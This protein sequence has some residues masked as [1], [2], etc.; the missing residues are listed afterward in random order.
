MMRRLAPERYFHTRVRKG[1]SG[2]HDT[3][4]ILG[5]QQWEAGQ[6]LAKDTLS[7]RITGTNGQLPRRALQSTL[8]DRCEQVLQTPVTVRN[9]CR[10]TLPAYPPAEDRFHWRVLSHLGSGF[11]NMMS[12]AEVLRGTLALYNW[13]DDELCNRKLDAI[14]DVQHHR[15]QRFENGYLLR[16]LEVEI[17]LDSN[18]FT[19]DG[20]INLFGEMLNRFL[21]LYAD[22]NQFI[23]LS[24]I[25]RPEGKCIRWKE[26]HS[27]R[28]PG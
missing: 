12:R 9:L 6:E 14:L 16:G 25:I 27:Q 22:M 28:L 2:L 18:G 19:G 7:L 4:L 15:L 13:Q 5:G 11:I 21:S 1:V 20:D 17:T 26:N 23:Q 10:P 8:L 3:W 24:L